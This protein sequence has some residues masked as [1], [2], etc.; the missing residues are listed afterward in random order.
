MV[1]RSSIY[2]LFICVLFS[3]KKEKENSALQ[4]DGLI[5]QKLYRLENVGWKSKTQV[6]KVDGINFTATEVPIEYYLLKDQGNQDLFLIDSL[7]KENKS[8]RIF[9]FTFEQENEE[10]LL[11]D[12]FT[13]LSYENGVKYMSFSINN[14]FYVVTS[15]KDTIQCSG[16]NFERSFKITPY[17]KI[18]LFFSGIPENDRIQLIYKD[19]LFNKGTLKFQFKDSY[20]EILL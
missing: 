20:T 13:K 12:K 3:C 15:K 11:Q 10:D 8:E 17:H 7:Y 4:N 2:I 14:D 6:E 18:I 19:K 16:V 5:R 9:E 1:L